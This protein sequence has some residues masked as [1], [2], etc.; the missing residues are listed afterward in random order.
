[1]DECKYG[2]KWEYPTHFCTTHAIVY[3][4]LYADHVTC[5]VAVSLVPW[6]LLIYIS[7]IVK[8]DNF[9]YVNHTQIKSWKPTSTKH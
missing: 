9:A 5:D 1:M 2:G 8:Q 6:L 4:H 3:L 7:L